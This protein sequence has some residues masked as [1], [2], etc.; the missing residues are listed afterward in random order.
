V[1][2]SVFANVAY[3]L[4]ESLLAEFS[5]QFFVRNNEFLANKDQVGVDNT[6]ASF[7]GNAGQVVV[8]KNQRSQSGVAIEF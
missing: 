5:G 6:A 2:S 3:D 4:F 1:P 7:F 8:F